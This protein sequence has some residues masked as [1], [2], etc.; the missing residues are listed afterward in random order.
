M[1]SF[2]L[3]AAVSVVLVSISGMVSGAEAPR[4]VSPGAIDRLA[5]MSDGCSAYSW[6]AIE[7][8]AGYEIVTYEVTEGTGQ[9]TTVDLALVRE[10]VFAR[11]PSGATSWTPD[12]ARCLAPGGRYA[13]FVRAIFVDEDDEVA[14]EWSDPLLLT[15][16][17]GLTAADVE[18]A[19]DVLLQYVDGDAEMGDGD[20][21]ILDASVQELKTT[22]ANRS[23]QTGT[24]AIKGDHPDLSGET[25][26][27]VGMSASPDGAGVGAA[28]TGGG[29]DLVLDGAA[30]LEADA[31]LSQRGIDRA[32][33]SPQTFDIRNSGGA[34]MTLMVDGTEV[35]TTATDQD[36]L[37]S[38][39][40]DEG[41]IP[42]LVGGVWICA[43]DA[44]A[45]G[46]LNCAMNEIPKYVGGVWVCAVDID[47]N[48]DVLASL[49]CGPSQ[50]AEWN[51]VSWACAPDDDALSSLGCSSGEVA[52]WNGSS[53]VCAGDDDTV[54]SIGQGLIVVGDEIRID[55]DVFVTRISTIEFTGASGQSSI[56]IGSDGLPI[57]SYRNEATDRL[58]VVHCN[59]PACTTRTVS[60]VDISSGA[61]EYNTIAIGG[62]GLALIAYFN[63]ITD[64]LK[65]AHCSNVECTSST[66]STLVP[67]VNVPNNRDSLAM[68]VGADGLGLVGY[69]DGFDLMVAHCDDSLC[70]TATASP[71]SADIDW[72][73]H[74]SMVTGTDGFGLILYGSEGGF[75]TTF[76]VAHCD[77]AACS[78]ATVTS[79]SILSEPGIARSAMVLGV[80]GLA[81][82]VVDGAGVSFAHCD[83]GLCSTSTSYQ[84][85]GGTHV[86]NI[87]VAIGSA[88]L[89]LIAHWHDLDNDLRLARCGDPV[90]T[91]ASFTTVVEM[92][93]VG[94]HS[95]IA[96]GPDGRGIVSYYDTGYQA[97]KV[98]HL[99]QDR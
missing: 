34:G 76:R 6:Q 39:S 21:G 3:S 24:A 28:N 32:W 26:G 63:G 93:N 79:S 29:P 67:S 44:D 36:T 90:C 22:V 27:V 61:G 85:F 13:W 57:I 51:G 33:S 78:S 50:V 20:D 40:C 49:P 95:S 88:G 59:D 18:R 10:V 81:L 52:K 60:D 42:T 9:D 97:L 8:A 19:L 69:G 82:A 25:Y 58:K 75:G 68:T 87:S 66:V 47:T 70:S 73:V 23:V 5:V 7:G 72:I 62:D 41:D 45:L 15:V 43:T 86:D 12:A 94:E 53:W 46:A 98:A 2:N 65:M 96:V 99:P 89:P 30:D 77:N 17:V 35:V 91:D 38:L 64:D 14:T 80:D 74:P 84:W 16:R 83:D 55:P 56:I 48:T 1:K 71:A 37:G 11:V 31:A 92:G 4:G 54:Y